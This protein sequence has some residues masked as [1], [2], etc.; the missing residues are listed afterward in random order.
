M[1]I[2]RDLLAGKYFFKLN[3]ILVIRSSNVLQLGSLKYVTLLYVRERFRQDLID[4]YNLSR[5]YLDHKIVDL[6]SDL[7]S[8][9]D[10]LS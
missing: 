5:N 2:A 4:T 8:E 3:N 1:L 9:Q 7:L 6:K 10:S